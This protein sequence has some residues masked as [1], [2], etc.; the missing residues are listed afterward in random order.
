MKAIQIVAPGRLELTE[1]LSRPLCAWEVRVAVAASCVCGSDLKNISAPVLVPQVPG[2]EF[3]GVVI[4]VST[5]AE[6]LC[7]V[8]DR[9]TAFP[10][11]G[12]MKCADCKNSRFRDCVDKLSIGFQLA[13]SFAEEVIVDSRL[14]VSLSDGLTYE[15]GALIEHLSCGYRLAKEIVSHQLQADAHIVLIGDGPIALADLQALRLFGYPNVTL[16]GKHPLRMGMARRLGAFRVLHLSEIEAVVGRKI[17]P[18]VDAIIMAA[19]AE[20]TLNQLLPLLRPEGLVF[21]QVS[22]KS[23][24]ILRSLKESKS[25][26]GRAFAYEIGDFTEV[27]S[28]I[29][30]GRLESESLITDRIDLLEFVGKFSAMKQHGNRS[31]TVII[32]K[33]LNEIVEGRGHE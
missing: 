2:H 32:N 21:P 31:K 22:I 8:G 28:L 10:M 18:L 13:G 12:C 26:F 14:V 6:S 19:P 23:P 3:S 24:S 30:E 20:Q 4:E 29:Q 33:K 17:L 27:M 7:Q 11:I 5:E 1:K 16:I 25:V 15:Q 9:V